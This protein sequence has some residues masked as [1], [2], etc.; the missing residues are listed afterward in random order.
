M[1][2]RLDLTQHWGIYTHS[3]HT[4]YMPFIV[5]GVIHFNPRC[6]HVILEIQ[7]NFHV[8]VKKTTNINKSNQTKNH[9]P[10]KPHVLSQL[11]IHWTR[12]AFK[13][14]TW[15]QEPS[16]HC[17]QRLASTL[18]AGLCDLQAGGLSKNKLWLMAF[19]F[20]SLEW[21]KY[22]LIPR[23]KCSGMCCREVYKSISD[24]KTRDWADARNALHCKQPEKGELT[25]LFYLK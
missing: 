6:S 7:H 4:A 5:R 22:T 15:I 24:A 16:S 23:S 12:T 20:P 11:Q 8:T 25:L 9:K 2:N 21:N 13:Q 3:M 14:Q 18:C 10:P 19:T 1:K 17:V